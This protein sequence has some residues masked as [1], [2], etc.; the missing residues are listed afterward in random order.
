MPKS[1]PCLKSLNKNLSDGTLKPGKIKL[2]VFLDLKSKKGVKFKKKKKI[3]PILLL[4]FVQIGSNVVHSPVIRGKDYENK[5]LYT[6]NKQNNFDSLTPQNL[7][8]CCT[9]YYFIAQAG[10]R[11]AKRMSKFR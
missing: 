1:K 10:S 2:E 3:F 9:P 5:K 7:Y 4:L 6:P 8:A 11:R